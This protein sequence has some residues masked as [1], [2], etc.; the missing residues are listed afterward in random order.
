MSETIETEGM[1]ELPIQWEIP[2]DLE[3]H[4]VNNLIVQHA[5]HEFI[6]SFFQ[7]LPPPIV[8]TPEEISAQLEG[9]KLK[10]KCVARVVVSSGRMVGFL[11]ALQDSM[12]K[13]GEKFSVTDGTE[14]AQ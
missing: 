2:D 13:H 1:I 8:G 12:R 5:E 6:I 9:V 7:T 14:E 10:S 11:Q 4:Y 3:T